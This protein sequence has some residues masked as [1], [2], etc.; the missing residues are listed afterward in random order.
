[1]STHSKPE[2]RRRR[3]LGIGDKIVIG[4]V[5]I[6]VIW[7]AYSLSQPSPPPT[8]STS[9]SLAPD[10]TL[11]VVGPTGL[12]GQKVSL[13]SF[14]GKVVFLEF[15][16]PQCVHCQ[17]MAPVLDK[18]YHQ[19]GGANVVF[20]SVSG[21]G[22]SWFGATADDV[23]NFIK[24][25]NTNW[26]YVIDTSNTVFSLYGVNS[27]PTFFIITKNGQVATV[28]VGETPY[29]TLATDLTRFSA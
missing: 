8:P 17:N 22:P 11:Q 13:S 21:S 18:L 26:I 24:A 14:R 23:A 10:F 7:A 25:Y 5:L 15:M 3:R 19:Y 2:K 1:M 28:Y 9:N 12:T 16:V 20:L 4:I 29:Q 6:V 27:T